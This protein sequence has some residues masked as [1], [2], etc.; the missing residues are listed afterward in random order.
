MSRQHSVP[1]FLSPDGTQIS[2]CEPV[3]VNAG[4]HG[5]NEEFFQNLVHQFPGV[6]PISEIDPIFANPVAVCTELSTPAGPIDNF[7]VT[8]GGLPVLVE[9]K[10][11]KNPEGRREVIGQILDYSKE[12]T[13]WSCSDLQREVNRRLGKS[14][15]TLVDIVRK[16]GHQADEIV[17]ND[18]LTFNLRRGR[19]LLIILGDGIREGVEAIGEYVQ[20]HAGLHFTFGLIEM[21]VYQAPSGE[22]IIVPRILARTHSIIRTVIA[23]PDGHTVID[24]E[25]EALD[26]SSGQP[27]DPIKIEQ[28]EKQASFRQQ[29]WEDFISLLKLD[30]PEQMIPRPG[31][32]TNLYF[33]LGAPGGS[34]WIS[35]YL[36]Q[37]TKKAGVFLSYTKGTAG[38]RAVQRLSEYV[39]D[40][41]RE[42]AGA[43]I[44]FRK[45]RPVIALRIATGDLEN[46]P[47]RERVLSWLRQHTND[48][49]NVLRPKVRSALAEISLDQS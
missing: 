33:M 6:L 3:A 13:K 5:Y 41:R 7:L 43:E 27:L 47:E 49:V 1:L 25:I 17:F 4:A 39:D 35:V 14:S 48:F 21:P 19:F 36:G 34:A 29:F 46:A 12:L 23:V 10:L 2:P 30:D 16:A 31:T 8:P 45:E 28:N 15:T 18:A 40:L 20:A 24:S 42:L 22:R 9:C 38:E 37:S 26:N 44:D 32:S 11:W